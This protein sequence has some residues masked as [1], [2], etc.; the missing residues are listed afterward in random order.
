[1]TC[2]GDP[3]YEDQDHLDLASRENTHSPSPALSSSELGLAP[4]CPVGGQASYSNDQNLS[5]RENCP[6]QSNEHM[7]TCHTT[8][9]HNRESVTL[10]PSNMADGTQFVFSD[11]HDTGAPD[12]HLPA[13]LELRDIYN[14]VQRS[15]SYN[16]AGVRRRVPSGL[17]IEAWRRYLGTYTD[18]NLPEFLE[19]GWPVHFDRLQPL[20]AADKNHFSAQAYPE[21]VDYY[22]ET[23]LAHGALLGP[24]AGPPVVGAHTSPLMSREKKDSE[25]RRI[26]V[27][28][29]C[30]KGFSINDGIPSTHYIDGPLSVKL[31]TVQTMEN[32]IIQ[33]GRGAFLYKTDLARGYRQ[34][35]VDPS[36]WGLLAFQHR[37]AF[38]LDIC[39]PFGLRS[40][41]MMMVRTTAAITQIH[42]ARGYES[43]A[44]IDDFGG[45]EATESE[46]KKA[47]QTLQEIFGEL[48]MMEAEKKICEPSQVMTWLGIE[49]NTLEMTMSLP[50]RKITEVA[51][52]VREWEQKKGATL[53][54][55]QSLFGLLQFVTHVAPSARLFTNRILECM[56][57]MG[58]DRYTSLS[59]GFRRDLKFFRDL[60]PAFKGVKIMDKSD[61]QAQHSLELDACLT[62]CGA[63]CGGQY[64]G[65][66]FP[67]QI[68]SEN[69]PI[70]HLELLN[71]V[72]AMKVWGQ[73][74]RGQRV[75]V[76]CDNMN[77]VLAIHTG[78][79]RDGY[80]QHCARELHYY[81]A[82]WDIEITASHA[83][84]TQMQ[85]ADA[86][87]RE[88]L[89]SKY[90]ARVAR[91]A[92]LQTAERVDP[93]DRCFMLISE[94]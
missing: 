28:L 1:M 60:M 38:Y 34:L 12:Q 29:S 42:K 13:S 53:R 63:V 9:L 75:R 17:N 32:R 5:E 46:A 91:D 22:I 20:V 7:P 2:S 26:I 73:S 94:L 39:P 89:D 92:R 50:E 74:W 82:L 93:D 78:R 55:I 90:A 83:P 66:T 79:T 70:A 27:D 14:E 68:L 62:G 56:R 86:L 71:V 24:F 52:C 4:Q 19:Y 88:H 40:S 30:P 44:Y 67:R 65:R 16:Y 64:Y 61:I 84:G 51:S 54:E 49:F 18:V 85:R 11:N 81:C 47:L 69:H 33:I 35:R 72:V 48:G 59:W 57:E 37:G 15:G 43:A 41:A 25:H 80:M 45:G 77:A 36:D 6:A 58:N 21:H 87:S 76:T 8:G 31:P 3:P 10:Q 23:E